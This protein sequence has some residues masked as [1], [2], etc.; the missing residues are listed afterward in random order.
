[1][2]KHKPT[3]TPHVDCGDYIV[4]INAEKV[5]LRGRRMAHAT[6]PNFTS[7]ILTKPYEHLTGYPGRRN[8]IPA[9]QL[10]ERKPEEILRLA[11][12]R[13]LPKNNLERYILNT[14]NLYRGTNHPHHSQVP[15]P[16]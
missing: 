7:K 11:A 6:H 16:V 12:R 1:M 2:G 4:V 8:I 13:M 3:Y 14:P 15:E 10:L 5:G 9:D